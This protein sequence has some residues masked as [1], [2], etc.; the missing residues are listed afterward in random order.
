MSSRGIDR[1]HDLSIAKCGSRY[2]VFVNSAWKSSMASRTG[3][4]V[5]AP[6]APISADSTVGATAWSFRPMSAKSASF[7]PTGTGDLFSTSITFSVVRDCSAERL[8][9]LKRCSVWYA[10]TG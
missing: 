9:V 3:Y 2:V 1:C 7:V 5:C 4:C 8:T 6:S 10:K